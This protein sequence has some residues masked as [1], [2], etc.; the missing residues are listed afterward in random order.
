MSNA[1]SGLLK[2]IDPRAPAAGAFP[3]GFHSWVPARRIDRSASDIPVPFTR[4]KFD[5]PA[6]ADALDTSSS[7][8]SAIFLMPAT[9]TP[10]PG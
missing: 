1:Q 7:A 6:M 2:L 3:R 5:A 4:T 10:Q 8:A 9:I